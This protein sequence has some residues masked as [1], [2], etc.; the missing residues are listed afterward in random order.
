MNCTNENYC[1]VCGS[2]AEPILIPTV[3]GLP[4]KFIQSDSCRQC[5]DFQ[6]LREDSNLRIKIFE[7]RK[8]KSGIPK[9]FWNADFGSFRVNSFNKKQHAIFMQY[10]PGQG[11]IFVSGPPGTGKTHLSIATLIKILESTEGIFSSVP[12]LLFQIKNSFSEGKYF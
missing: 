1:T 11:S 10:H 2:I 5:R 9:R 7:S 4:E 3:L 6:S 12:D 8:E